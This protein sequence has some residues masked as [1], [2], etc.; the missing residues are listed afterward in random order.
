MCCQQI[1]GLVQATTWA[2]NGKKSSSSYQ[3]PHHRYLTKKTLCR[4]TG[5]ATADLV[6]CNVSDRADVM[7]AS[8]V[9]QVCLPIDYPPYDCKVPR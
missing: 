5:D 1:S 2:T 7:Y 9:L 8:S 6:P 3:P 4:V